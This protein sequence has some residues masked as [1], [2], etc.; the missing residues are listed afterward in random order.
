MRT[1]I[2]LDEWKLSIFERNLK[3]AGFTSGRRPGLTKGTLVF[4]VVIPD[5]AASLE[6]LSSVIQASNDEACLYRTP[7]NAKMH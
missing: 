5:D 3:D 2:V 4:A 7:E 6:K 1:A